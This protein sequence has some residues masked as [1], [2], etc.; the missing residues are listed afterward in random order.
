MGMMRDFFDGF[1]DGLVNGG[2][3]H[4]SSRNGS[5]GDHGRIER[6]CGELGWSVDEREGNLVRLYFNSSDGE[7][8]KVII[9]NGDGS[10]VGFST[11]SKSALPAHRVPPDLLAYLMR[12]NVDNSG[13]GTWGMDDDDDEA[14]FI[15]SYMALGAGLD[16]EKFGYICESLSK[17]ANDFDDKLRRAGLLD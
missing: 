12:R 7:R 11:Y 10:V 5:A 14:T 13:I 15:I 17:E 1:V 9:G 3:N 2:A 6:L 16:A 4:L 8:R